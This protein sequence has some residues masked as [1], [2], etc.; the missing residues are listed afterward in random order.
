MQYTCTHVQAQ[1]NLCRI[2]VIYF[3]FSVSLYL[4]FFIFQIIS[5]YFW[6][7]AWMK[8]TNNFQIDQPQ[9]VAQ[10]LL[11]FRPISAWCCLQ[12]CCFIKKACF[13]YEITFLINLCNYFSYKFVS[14]K[15]PFG[16]FIL[17]GFYIKLF[18]IWKRKFLSKT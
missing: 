18:L 17:T 3:S 13:F 8:K 5:Y 10:L 9:G 16:W 1:V 14:G 6:M 4:F 7:I 2:Y 15:K 12:K 11:H